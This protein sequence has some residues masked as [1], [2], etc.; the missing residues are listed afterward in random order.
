M[1][2]G[3]KAVDLIQKQKVS[4]SLAY[5]IQRRCRLFW[6]EISLRQWMDEQRIINLK[7]LLGLKV[8]NT[9]TN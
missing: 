7:L 9:K 3:R 6:F 5:K 4:R 2:Y 8:E 1:K